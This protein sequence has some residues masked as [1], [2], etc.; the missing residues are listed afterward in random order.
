MRTAHF[1]TWSQYHS[2]LLSA[3]ILYNSVILLPCSLNSI[4]ISIKTSLIS[5]FQRISIIASWRNILKIL[6]PLRLHLFYHIIQ[7]LYSPP[8][9]KSNLQKLCRKR[10][11]YISQQNL[12]RKKQSALPLI[13]LNMT[14]QLVIE[15]ES[16]TWIYV[17][18]RILFI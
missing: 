12:R 3:L 8:E 18:W 7:E 6:L 16:N 17:L 11:H 9:I 1:N 14:S 4:L 15:I 5:S 2:V 10:S 13:T